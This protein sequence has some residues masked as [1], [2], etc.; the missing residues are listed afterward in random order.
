MT[1]FS[2]IFEHYGY[3]HQAEKLLE[4]ALELRD[5]IVM[6]DPV[7]HIAEEVA[8]VMVLLN[9]IIDAYGIDMNLVSKV[10]DE[11]VQ[12]QVGRIERGE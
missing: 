11:K 10:I 5:A 2:D 9:Q 12:R 1:V 8:D 7:E 3:E 4:E 6:L